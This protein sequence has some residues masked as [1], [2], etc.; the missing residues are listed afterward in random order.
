MKASIAPSQTPSS[1]SSTATPSPRPSTTI[2]PP[3][4]SGIAFENSADGAEAYAHFLF[5][6]WWY[7]IN[8]RDI[9]W[10]DANIPDC[11]WKTAMR[12]SA[13]HLIKNETLNETAPINPQAI[14]RKVNP[15]NGS[16]FGITLHAN[17]SDIYKVTKDGARSVAYPGEKYELIARLLHNGISWDAVAV[18]TQGMD[19]SN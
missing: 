16:E 10:W 6:A 13:L 8:T 18:V 1:P 5:Q 17:V 19:D 14:S 4:P 11:G 15:E 3:I 2:Q 7:L 12:D 9:E